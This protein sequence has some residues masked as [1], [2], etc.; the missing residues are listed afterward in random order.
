MALE[1]EAGSLFSS[2]HCGL[3]LSFS[4][5]SPTRCSGAFG[6]SWSPPTGTPTS[7]RNHPRSRGS[8]PFV[9]CVL[10][11]LFLTGRDC[12]FCSCPWPGP[13]LPLRESDS[14]LR[15]GMSSSSWAIERPR[16]M[17]TPKL[18]STLR[19]ITFLDMSAF[20]EIHQTLVVRW[21]GLPLPS[22]I[23]IDKRPPIAKPVDG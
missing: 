18:R 20:R 9:C 15:T 22:T 16:S 11:F 10:F 6:I 21:P 12:G 4:R 5:P 13:R 14:R 17:R 19:S 8:V 2:S 23:T 1:G 7:G 3:C